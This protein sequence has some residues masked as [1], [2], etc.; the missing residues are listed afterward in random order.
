MIPQ[1]NELM[2]ELK[3][4]EKSSARESE[5]ESWCLSVLKQVLG[6]SASAGYVVKSQEGRGRRRFDLAITL[7]DQ[8]DK[9]V[10]VVEVK[11]LGADLD[12]S[13]LRSG[14][15]QLGDYLKSLGGVRWGILTNGY[16]WRLYDFRSDFIT[17]TSTDLRNEQQEL[18]VD[19]SALEDAAWELLDFTASYFDHGMWGKLSLEAQAL[20][21][22]SLARAV[23]SVDVV[24]RIGRVLKEHRD[25]RVP[26]DV[27]TDKLAELLVSGLNDKLSCW[28]E[29][30]R[31]EL[32]RYI[33]SQKKLAKKAKRKKEEAST[34]APE[35]RSTGDTQSQMGNGG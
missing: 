10:L 1:L 24:K 35:E 14:R 5:V 31:G 13:D 7:A 12:K 4:L 33:R 25:Y 23:L 26:L 28:N 16:D 22:D 19:P 30:Q 20:S 17:V 15:A 27:L 34:K 3:N 18:S 9:I 32:D 2:V 21:P 11:K 8:P 29:M 6:F